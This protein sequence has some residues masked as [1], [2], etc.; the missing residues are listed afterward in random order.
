MED[1]PAAPTKRVETA[2]RAPF[3]DRAHAPPVRG[4]TTPNHGSDSEHQD[5]AQDRARNRA[6]E[7]SGTDT[8]DETGPDG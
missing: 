6:D 3:P 5:D 7:D 8:T 2:T 1:H 4:T